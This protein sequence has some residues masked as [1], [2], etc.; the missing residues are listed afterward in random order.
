M[1]LKRSVAISK[2]YEKSEGK[3]YEDK[4]Y[5]CRHIASMRT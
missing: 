5:A 3:I 4:I 1:S 2:G